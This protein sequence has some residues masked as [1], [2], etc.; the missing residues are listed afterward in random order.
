[1]GRRAGWLLATLVALAACATDPAW[2]FPTAAPLPAGAVAVPIRVQP[3]P[4]ESSDVEFACPAALLL[5]VEM[6]VDR[7]VRPPTISFR[8]IDSGEPAEIEW[9]WGISAYEL[10]GVVH[11]VAPDGEDLMVE[12]QVADDLGGGGGD[13]VFNMCDVRSL[14]H[15]AGSSP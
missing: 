10:D 6:I 7:S 5:P 14:P 11:I 4:D 15:R 13:E 2:I 3:I 8:F 12:G 9:S 1:M